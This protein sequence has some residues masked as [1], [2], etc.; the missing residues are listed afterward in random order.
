MQA[1]LEKAEVAKTKATPQQ[2]AVLTAA[3]NSNNEDEIEDV[4]SKLFTGVN[5]GSGRRRRKTAGRR[6]GSKKVGARRSQKKMPKS[7]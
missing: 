3:I 6:R 1:L 4:L 5:L 2:L 7:R